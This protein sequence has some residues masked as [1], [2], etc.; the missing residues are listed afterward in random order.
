MKTKALLLAGLMASSS[1]ASLQAQTVYSI[2]AVGFINVSA[3]QGFS[4]VANQLAGTA[5]KISDIL[6]APP[7]GTKVFKFNGT[8]FDVFE[9]LGAP[10]NT[11][12]PSGDGTFDLGGGAFVSN[13][14]ASPLTLTFVGEVPTGEVVNSLPAGFSIKSSMIP[15]AG[16]LSSSL[17]F[18][19][20][21]TDK[22]YLFNG[23]SYDVHELLGAPFNAW[24]PSEPSVEVGEAF[25]VF[26]ANAGN[27]TRNFTV[28]D[29]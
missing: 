9:F 29:E 19:A 14:S 21:A 12:F 6:P 22:V 1:L 2:N 27:W 24:F 13:P 18:P 3:P 17:G 10:F 7:V 25:F 23:T 20:S 15:Q 26:K 4:M 11:W 8:G 5:N 16:A 28:S